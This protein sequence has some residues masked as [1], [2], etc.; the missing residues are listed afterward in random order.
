MATIQPLEE[1]PHPFLLGLHLFL[2]G[3]HPSESVITN[4][5]HMIKF[6]TDHIQTTLHTVVLGAMGVT[7]MSRIIMMKMRKV[8][9]TARITREREKTTKKSM[10]KS[11]SQNTS[12]RK[13]TLAAN[14]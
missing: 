11:K 4:K 13:I 6:S 14:R 9:S 5:E 1:W 3:L 2:L 8:D 12:K 10:S 7:E